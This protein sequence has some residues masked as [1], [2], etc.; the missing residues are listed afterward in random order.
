MYAVSVYLHLY[1][2]VL[3][4][5]NNF[6]TRVTNKESPYQ[7]CPTE[8][9]PPWYIYIITLL[10]RPQTAMKA[11]LRS[12]DMLWWVLVTGICPGEVAKYAHEPNKTLVS[13]AKM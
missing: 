6:P 1:S 9:S 2:P 4:Q 7:L 5:L 3:D 10:Q 8:D 13:V 12:P 11:V